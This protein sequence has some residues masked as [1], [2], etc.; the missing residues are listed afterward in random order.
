MTITLCNAIG[1]ARGHYKSVNRSKIYESC[2]SNSE[3]RA[4]LVAAVTLE[5]RITIVI[6]LEFGSGVVFTVRSDKYLF[7]VR[8]I[9]I[10]HTCRKIINAV[11]V[12][13]GQRIE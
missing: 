6:H 2:S 10:L 7:G 5:E 1:E 11:P 4:L 3:T 9:Y 12:Y 8:S 13:R